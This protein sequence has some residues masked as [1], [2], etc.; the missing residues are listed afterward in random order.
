M[1]DNYEKKYEKVSS[2]G[3]PPKFRKQ[4]FVSLPV[5]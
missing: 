2:V 4:F 3:Q 1:K 5:R